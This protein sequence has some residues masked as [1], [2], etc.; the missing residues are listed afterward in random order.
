M[1][2]EVDDEV[3]FLLKLVNPHVL[4]ASRTRPCPAS[5]QTENLPCLLPRV[6]PLHCGKFVCYSQVGKRQFKPSNFAQNHQGVYLG[7][8]KGLGL[9]RAPNGPFVKRCLT[10]EDDDLETDGAS[11]MP[12]LADSWEEPTESLLDFESNRF[13]KAPFK[14]FQLRVKDLSE[15]STAWSSSMLA[16]F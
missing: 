7:T 3:H 11:R 16:K 1:Q 10:E 2:D 5:S 6:K 14:N 9:Y 4:T 12:S 13:L 15:P 8:L